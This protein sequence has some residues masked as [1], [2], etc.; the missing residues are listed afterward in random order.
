LTKRH[1]E[2]VRGPLADIAEHFKL[3][4]PRGEFTLVVAGATGEELTFEDKSIFIGISAPNHVFALEAAGMAR[5]EAIREVARL[6]GLPKREVYRAV[7]DE[8][9]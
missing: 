7:I 4:E 1:E 9:R 6:R 3:N 2:V 8:S 5:K